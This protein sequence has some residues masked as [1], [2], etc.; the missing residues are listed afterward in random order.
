ML[1]GDGMCSRLMLHGDGERA[2]SPARMPPTSNLVRHGQKYKIP[3]SRGL[4]AYTGMRILVSACKRV[5]LGHY[6][7]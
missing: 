1:H 4:Y 3:G 2:A 6:S 7:H 5:I